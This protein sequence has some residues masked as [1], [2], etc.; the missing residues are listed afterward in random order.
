[1]KTEIDA[2]VVKKLRDAT[3]AGM[4]NCKKALLDNDGDYDLVVNNVNMP[5][6]IYRNETN[7]TANWLKIKL[8][9]ADGNT[10][11]IDASGDA[12]ARKRSG[13]R[14]LEQL[15]VSALSCVDNGRC[16]RMFASTLQASGKL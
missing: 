4:M 14:S 11:A 15:Q 9:G 1:M 2:K 5:C 8:R 13:P 10:F 12:L 6:F 3:G 16:H 7:A